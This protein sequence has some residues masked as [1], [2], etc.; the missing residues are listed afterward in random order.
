MVKVVQESAHH[1]GLRLMMVVVADKEQLSMY[2]L[3]SQQL[4]EDGGTE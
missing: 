3:N 4:G 2:L 1:D